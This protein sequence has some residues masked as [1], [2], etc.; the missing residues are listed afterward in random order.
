ME[1]DARFYEL[2]GRICDRNESVASLKS[3]ARELK[4]AII[5]S[6][7]ADF[8][9]TSWRILAKSYEEKSSEILR[10]QNELNILNKEIKEL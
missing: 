10:L 1:K 5:S 4:E 9:L 2:K 3:E 8:K 7:N 6:F